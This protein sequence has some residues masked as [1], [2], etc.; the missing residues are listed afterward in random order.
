MGVSFPLS[1]VELELMA[2]KFEGF[3]GDGGAFFGVGV[4]EGVF[5]DGGGGFAVVEVGRE[6]SFFTGN[7]L[8]FFL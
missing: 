4:V 1:V 8:S 3:F 6:R 7:F 2:H 5:F